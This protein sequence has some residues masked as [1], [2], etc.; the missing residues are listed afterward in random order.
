MYIDRAIVSI[1]T[2]GILF[3]VTF[4]LINVALRKWRFPKFPS[5]LRSILALGLSFAIVS[6]FLNYY[7]YHGFG[8]QGDIF[9]K[10]DPSKPWVAITFDDGP[11]PIWTPAIL[12]V[13]AEHEV[14]A[15]FFMVGAHVEKYP[16]VANRVVQEGHEV[17]NHTF[18]HVNIPSTRLSLLSA[19]MLK[20]TMVIMDITGQYPK[21]LRPPRGMYDSR[22]RRL[23]ELLGQPIV[24]WTI[25]AQD[26]R[27]GANSGTIERRIVQQVR[28]GDILLF[29]DSGALISAEGASRLATVQS[30]PA[31]IAGIREK[32]LQIVTLEQ[33][34]AHSEPATDIPEE[35]TEYMLE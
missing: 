23:A 18:D 19:Q 33:L 35:Q 16:D 20:T 4:F 5:W 1:L 22:V 3:L 29:H 11:H 17:G 2:I 10:G 15:A 7:V 21:Y 32:G 6:L 25:S 8:Y 12:D 27:P 14:P 26:W 30:L 28:P 34:L 9:R 31:I 24:L 13:L